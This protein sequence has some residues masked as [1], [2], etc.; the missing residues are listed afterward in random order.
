[1]WRQVTGVL[2]PILPHHI[3]LVQLG[4][5]RKRIECNQDVAS[6]GVDVALVE[7]V[8][9]CLKHTRLMQEGEVGEVL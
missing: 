5:G 6:V 3:W 7:A 4:Q 2:L 8:A 9:Q 1:M